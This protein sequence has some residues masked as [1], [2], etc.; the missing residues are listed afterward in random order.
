MFRYKLQLEADFNK[1]EDNLVVPQPLDLIKDV[2]FYFEESQVE[3]ARL[4][5]APFV[6]PDWNT[7]L[8]DQL[9]IKAVINYNTDMV[10]RPTNTIY[11]YTVEKNRP[12]L[13]IEKDV[14]LVVRAAQTLRKKSSR[15]L[16]NA[17]GGLPHSE[18]SPALQGEWGRRSQQLYSTSSA[19][20]HSNLSSTST[21][22]VTPG[23]G[24]M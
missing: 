17:N 12:G 13:S 19:E 3:R 4:T 21:S 23:D 8:K 15:E 10:V 7:D 18:S 9:P 1:R 20:G 16:I 22:S 2:T 24:S 11:H 5:T 6:M 14:L